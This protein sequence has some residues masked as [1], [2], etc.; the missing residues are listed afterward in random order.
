[1][2]KMI[3]V[4]A[5]SLV[6]ASAFAQIGVVAG[7]TSSQTDVKSA[8]EQASSLNQYHLGIAMK[9]D[10]G[11]FA[12]QPELLYN[13]KG[14]ALETIGVE[15]LKS[16]SLKTGYIELPVQVQAAVKFGRAAR[17]YAFG[18]P[19]L[20]YAVTNEQ[21]IISSEDLSSAAVWQSSWDNVKSRTEFGVSLGAGAELFESFQ[22]SLKYFWNFGNMY[23]KEISFAD[24]KTTVTG[25]KCSGIAASLAIFF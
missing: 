1:M 6:A 21:K 13:V 18:E 7:V 14:Q 17:L 4:L 19:F 3:S 11:L 24:I 9:I 10:L 25:E 20:G 15:S 22:L 16:L 2:K 12:I 23:G 8:V 5:A